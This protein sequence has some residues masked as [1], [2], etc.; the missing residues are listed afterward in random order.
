MPIR[1]F[2]LLTFLLLLPSFCFAWHGRVVAITDGDTLTVLR[3]YEQV[4]IRI[5]GI[6]A[7]ERAQPWGDR[8]RQALGDLVHDRD[9]EVQEMAHDRYGRTVALVI[10]RGRDVSLEMV[11]RG[12]AWVYERYC[13]VPACEVMRRA[14]T[15]A[16]ATRSGLWAAP[17]PIPPWEWRH[18]SRL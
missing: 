4:R 16:Q 8:A 17:D 13:R 18:H 1:A 7:P 14:Q 11:R 9:V 12:L 5:Y 2:A 15:E 6:D 3:E 10:A